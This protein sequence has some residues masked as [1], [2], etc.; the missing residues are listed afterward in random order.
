MTRAVQAAFGVLAG[1]AVASGVLRWRY[2]VV[3]VR[4]PSMEPDL[5]DGDRLLARRCGPGRLRCGELVVFSEPGIPGRRAAR[6]TRAAAQGWVIKR[7]AALPGDPVPASCRPAVG[8]AAVVPP[9]A[10][11]V[12][13]TAPI[14][15]DSPH[16]GFVPARRI[17]G[18][19]Q[20][21]L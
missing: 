3:T 8:G 2:C 19:G 7:V 12:L 17:F 6:L 11:V 16:W 1:L 14:S 18:T 21:R 10:I 5:T 9:G 20:R 13:G 15:R 4:G